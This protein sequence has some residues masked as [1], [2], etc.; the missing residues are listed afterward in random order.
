[1][2]E[3]S[4]ME[5]A[6]PPWFARLGELMTARETVR[7]PLRLPQLAQM[8]TQ[9]PRRVLLIPGFG[10]TDSSLLPLSRFLRLVGHR[11]FASR[12]GRVTDD[13]E[14]QYQLVI[15]RAEAIAD[16]QPISLV[17][18]SI[19]GVLSREAARDRPDLFD[20]VI[21]LASP[22]VGG[23]SYTAM[24]RTYQEPTLRAIRQRIDERNTIPIEVPITAIWS[25]H[26]GV[27]S[28]HACI[29]NFSPNVRHVEVTTTHLG[30]GIDPDVWHAVVDSLNAPY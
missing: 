29:D 23:P 20:R 8:R 24:A 13:V 30:M 7:L 28:H 18:W 11:T 25:K 6:P 5:L 12:L 17:G 22:V 19:G 1:M 9:T 27:V 21:T 10:A 3:G 4:E 26:D 16:G 2:I 15:E 14:A